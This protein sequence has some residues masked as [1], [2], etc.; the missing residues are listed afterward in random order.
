VFL[1]E[2]RVV[3]AD[4]RV[5]P[6]LHLDLEFDLRLAR[7]VGGGLDDLV[8]LDGVVDL[9]VQAG[10]RVPG[11]AGRDEEREVDESQERS[12][13]R[14]DG[15]VGE[16]GGLR[17]VFR[18][19]AEAMMGKRAAQENPHEDPCRKSRVTPCLG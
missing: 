19:G 5:L 18:V 17:V 6:L 3:A 14:P 1:V 8:F 13:A 15:E 2:R 10:D 12:E 4:Q 7:E 16:H 9:V 11:I